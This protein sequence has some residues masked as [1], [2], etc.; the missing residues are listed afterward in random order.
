MILTE[1]LRAMLPPGLALAGSDPRAAPDRLW[2]AEATATARMTPARLREF[3]AGRRAARAAMAALGLPP[4]AIP[5]GA[6]RAP[7]LARGPHRHDQP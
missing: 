6:T 1:A 5:M 2:P 3:A 7:G 4:A